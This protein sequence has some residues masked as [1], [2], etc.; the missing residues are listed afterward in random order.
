MR[1]LFN[2]EERRHEI[3]TSRPWFA[4]QSCN[5]GNAQPVCAEH[6]QSIQATSALQDIE[7]LVAFRF[8]ITRKEHRDEVCCEY[9]SEI[10]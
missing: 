8:I 3:M 7:R 6:A 4:M 1:S 10:D 9:V 2:L 5:N